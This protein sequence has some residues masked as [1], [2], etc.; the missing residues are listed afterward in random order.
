[1]TTLDLNKPVQLI[2]ANEKKSYGEREIV[3]I[4][5]QSFFIRGMSENYWKCSLD[6]TIE[7]HPAWRVSNVPPPT[8]THTVH[9]VWYKTYDGLVMLCCFTN[10]E[11]ADHTVKSLG[12][13]VIARQDISITV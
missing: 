6:G 5:P 3:V 11:Y 13:R 4:G 2:T 9:G 1:M 10:T 7:G 12:P 8:V